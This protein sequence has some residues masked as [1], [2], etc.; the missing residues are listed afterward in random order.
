MTSLL[1]LSFVR[2]VRGVWMFHNDALLMA[3]DGFI[4]RIHDFCPVNAKPKVLFFPY[5]TNQ[6]L[7]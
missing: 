6:S 1:T 2:P 4:Q 5:K 7:T 3:V